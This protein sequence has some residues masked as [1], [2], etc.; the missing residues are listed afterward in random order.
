MG[1]IKLLRRLW[2]RPAGTIM[3]ASYEQEMFAVRKGYAEPYIKEIE[4]KKAKVRVQKNKAE[5]PDENKFIG[6]KNM[7]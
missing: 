1:K 5:K 6:H 4:P 2:Q 7:K 3:D